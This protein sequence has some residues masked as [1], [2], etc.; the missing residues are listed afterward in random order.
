MSTDTKT[1]T[2]AAPFFYPVVIT[3]RD[4]AK[5][6]TLN[7]DGSVEADWPA[8]AALKDEFMA[9]CAAAAQKPGEARTVDFVCGLAAAL[10][11]AR[12]AR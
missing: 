4:D 12:N 2:P 10:W 5:L 9:N 11:H 7:L 8:I 3:G 6:F 1:P